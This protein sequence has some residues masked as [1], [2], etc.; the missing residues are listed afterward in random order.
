MIR[1]ALTIFILLLVWVALGFA[2]APF[3]ADP[4]GRDDETRGT[5]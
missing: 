2:V 1:V 3:C 4:S 5:R